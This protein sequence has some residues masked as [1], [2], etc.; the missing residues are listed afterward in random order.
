MGAL[1]CNTA[2]NQYNSK[3]KSGEK[4]NLSWERVNEKR[5]FERIHTGDFTGMPVEVKPLQ[6]CCARDGRTPPG[7]GPW[8]PTGWK[9]VPLYVNTIL[10]PSFSVTMAFFQLDV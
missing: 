10:S 5:L 4:W 1:N 7:F 9:P 8:A 2:S 6:L 3:G